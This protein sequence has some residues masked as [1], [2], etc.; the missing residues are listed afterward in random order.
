MTCWPED[1]GTPDQSVSGRF[2]ERQLVPLRSKTAQGSSGGRGGGGLGA[3]PQV[4][5]ARKM[6]TLRPRTVAVV[7]SR[8][9]AEAGGRI[10][11]TSYVLRRATYCWGPGQGS[12]RRRQAPPEAAGHPRE[13]RSSRAL[14]KVRGA[15]TRVKRPQPRGTRYR[16]WKVTAATWSRGAGQGNGK[17]LDPSLGRRRRESAASCRS[18]SRST[19]RTTP[20]SLIGEPGRGAKDGD[21][22]R[23]REGGGR[24]RDSFSGR[25]VPRGLAGDRR[26]IALDSGRPGTPGGRSSRARSREAA[27][28][29]LKGVPG[30]QVAGAGARPFKRRRCTWWFG[31]GKGGGL[32]MGRRKPAPR[33]LAPSG[34]DDGA[35]DG[36]HDPGRTSNAGSTSRRTRAG[37]GGSD[38]SF[39][40]EPTVGGTPFAS[41]RG[42]K[43]ARLRGPHTRSDPAELGLGSRGGEGASGGD[44]SPTASSPKRPFDLVDE[45]WQGGAWAMEAA[46]VPHRKDRRPAAHGFCAAPSAWRSG[47]SGARGGGSTGPRK[48]GSWRSRREDRGS[49][50]GKGSCRDLAP[51]SG[52]FE[53]SF[54]GPG[55]ISRRSAEGGWAPAR[56]ELQTAPGRD[57]RKQQVGGGEASGRDEVALSGKLARL[58]T[59][60]AGIIS[61][62]EDRAGG[63]LPGDSPPG[64]GAGGCKKG[65]RNRRRVSRE[66]V[67]QGRA[68]PRGRMLTTEGATS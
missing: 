34:G 38:P 61:R 22:R 43:A 66:F 7:S 57:P 54:G 51:A 3:L 4:Q 39:V 65:G 13:R 31:A 45:A 56:S 59:R 63:G 55:D 26:V 58:G 32:A 1:A 62:G 14:P 19:K 11:G 27:Q 36:S 44:T 20:F 25:S 6:M 60:S 30:T 46:I 5:G 52:R 40:G 12:P 23:L 68:H 9:R 2:L 28:E 41:S 18:S 21:R 42:L 50:R 49:G 47:C 17:K 64:K 24:R 8:A 29:V 15:G 48:G 33:G 37:C 53:K 16:R 10:E 35:S 67:S